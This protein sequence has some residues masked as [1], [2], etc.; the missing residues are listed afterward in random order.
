M[1]QNFA[2]LLKFNIAMLIM[3]TSGALGRFIHLPPPVIIWARC[4]IAALV[5]FLFIWWQKTPVK[6]NK[7]HIKI[8]FISSVFLGIHW[9]TYFYALHMSN[10]AI[11]FLSIF[12]YP[13]ITTLLEP[14]VLKTKFAWSN[15]LLAFLVLLGVFFMVPEFTLENNATIGLLFGIFS[16]VFYSFRNLLLKKNIMQYSGST[17]MFY[18]LAINAVLLCPVLFF[19]EIENLAGQ[20]PALATLGILTTAVGHTLFVISF[21]RFSISAVSIM[22]SMQPLMGILIAFIFLD[23]V[24]EMKTLIGGFLILGTV[25]VESSRTI[26]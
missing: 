7:K 10:V 13:V 15:L 25:V 18:Q 8:I 1:N 11:G 17:L 19:F 16:A 21:R 22:S 4:L 3:S 12:T 6:L 24:P 23:E 20:L 26:K 2:Y 5:L 14:I 9:I